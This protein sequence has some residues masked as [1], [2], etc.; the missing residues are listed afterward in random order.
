MVVDAALADIVLV[1]K[2][3]MDEWRK[4]QEQ[5]KNEMEETNS[6]VD[7]K[8]GELKYRYE[9]QLQEMERTKDLEIRDLEKR[10]EDL[11]N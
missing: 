5:L 7:Y 9:T 4:R 11:K 8:I 10:Y 1:K 2:S 3:E 6:K